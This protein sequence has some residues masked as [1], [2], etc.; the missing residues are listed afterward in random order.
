MK[1]KSREQRSNALWLRGSELNPNPFTNNR[2]EF[3]KS[4]CLALKHGKQFFRAHH[5]IAFA[6]RKIDSRI[7]SAV[8]PGLPQVICGLALS[9]IQLS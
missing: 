2:G 5:L 1:T 7:F 9:W 6:L 4:R 3:K 8:L